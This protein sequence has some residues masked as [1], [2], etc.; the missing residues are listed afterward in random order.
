MSERIKNVL[1]SILISLSMTSNFISPIY[2]QEEVDEEVIVENEEIDEV[3]E[4]ITED[5][6]IE[7]EIIEEVTEEEPLEEEEAD[8]EITEEDCDA[9]YKD[10]TYDVT[11]SGAIQLIN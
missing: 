2:A 3:T 9:I 11:P 6:I 10:Y 1:I 7:E 5:E 8:E 4:E